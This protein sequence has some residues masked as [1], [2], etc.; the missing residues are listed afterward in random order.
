MEIQPALLNKAPVLEQGAKD[1]DGTEKARV[2]TSASSA[3]REV[4]RTPLGGPKS[5]AK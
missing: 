5:R 1:F 4:V 2:K 3:G